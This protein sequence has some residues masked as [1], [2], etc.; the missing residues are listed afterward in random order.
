MMNPT[1]KVGKVF[2]RIILTHEKNFQKEAGVR[3]SQCWSE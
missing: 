1:R 3:E 2:H